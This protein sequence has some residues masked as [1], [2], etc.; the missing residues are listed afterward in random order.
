MEI[1]NAVSVRY[2]SLSLNDSHF[3]QDLLILRRSSNHII[4]CYLSKEPVK[5][6]DIQLSKGIVGGAVVQYIGGG[7]SQW[8]ACSF[9]SCT[10]HNND[11]DAVILTAT[12]KYIKAK[13][14]NS[15]NIAKDSAEWDGSFVATCIITGTSVL[16]QSTN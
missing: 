2:R 8:R 9:D 4:R 7:K 3:G 10:G 13:T 5:K 12:L 11:T 6:H 1:L 15:N 14:V 16:T